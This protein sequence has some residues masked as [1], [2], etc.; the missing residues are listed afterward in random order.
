V[1]RSSKDDHV[2]IPSDDD[3]P[4]KADRLHILLAGNLDYYLAIS[5]GA[6]KDW[7]MGP[8]FRACTSGARNDFATAVIAALFHRARGDKQSAVACLRIAIAEVSDRDET[9]SHG[10]P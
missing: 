7:P 2:S 9:G 10:P 1:K 5:D 6:G 3:S 8:A 4:D